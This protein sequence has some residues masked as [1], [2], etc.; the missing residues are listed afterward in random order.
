MSKGWKLEKELMDHLIKK[1]G[2]ITLRIGDGRYKEEAFWYDGKYFRLWFDPL[3]S[4]NNPFALEAKAYSL[5]PKSGRAK[6]TFLHKI[7]S[8]DSDVEEIFKEIYKSKQ[9]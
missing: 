6:S 7:V 5:D 1:Y 9:R 4:R 3:Y 8:C 2:A